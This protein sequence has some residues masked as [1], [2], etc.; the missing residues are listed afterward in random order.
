[1]LGRDLFRWTNSFGSRGL[2]RAVVFGVALICAPTAA[3]AQAAIAGVVRDASGA[4]LPGVTVEASSPALIER[5]RSAISD[6]TGQYRIENLRPG[7]YS[8][9]FTLAGFSTVQREGIELTGSA[10]VPLSVDL[11]VGALEETVTVTGETPTVDVQNARRQTVL[12]NDV[13]NATRRQAATTRSSCSSPACSVVSRTS[14]RGRAT[15]ARS[16]RTARCSQAGAPTARPGSSSTASAS[17]CRRRAA[18]TTS[19]IHATR[20]K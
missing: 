1:M 12:T 9:K 8:V 5:V 19:R 10:T 17:P 20:R 6:S 13:I 11:K 7:T 14:A 4:V 3:F 2:R 16:A 18:R 15:R